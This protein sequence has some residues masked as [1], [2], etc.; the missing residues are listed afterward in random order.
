LPDL[1]RLAEKEITGGNEKL[2]DLWEVTGW[3]IFVEKCARLADFGIE[4][5]A[6]FTVEKKLPIYVQHPAE[7][8]P[9]LLYPIFDMKVW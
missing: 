4:K 7:I 2:P 8:S 3:L 5:M 9:D 1:H 6:R